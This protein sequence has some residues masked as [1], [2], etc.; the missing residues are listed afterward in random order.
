TIVYVY[1][2]L[3][4]QPFSIKS[5]RGCS[6]QEQSRQFGVLKGDAAVD[7]APLQS[8]GDRYSAGFQVQGATDPTPLQMQSFFMNRSTIVTPKSEEMQESRSDLVVGRLT[9]RTRRT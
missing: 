2:A 8:N 3:A 6:L 9:R 4:I 5:P 7:V 1:A